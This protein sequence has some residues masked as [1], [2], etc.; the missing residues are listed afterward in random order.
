M[1]AYLSP[2]LSRFVITCDRDEKI[3]ITNYQKSEIIESYCLGHL[4]FVSA[5]AELS[6]NANQ[7]VSISGDKTLRLWNYLDG[8]ELHRL[9]LSGRGVRFAQNERDEIAAVLFDENYKIAIFE[10]F[11]N[12]ENKTSICLAAE[13]ACENVKY[14]SSI[15]YETNDCVWFAGLD[16]NDEILLKQLKIIR[17]N[18]KVHMEESDADDVLKILKPNLPTTKLQANEDITQLFKKAFDNLTDYKE[19]KKRRIEKKYGK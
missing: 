17:T 12:D 9:E 3:R 1:I 15:M 5:I 6:S 7:L 14:I 18:E 11:T 16:G 2:F 19:R 10:P 8:T 13:H 4:E